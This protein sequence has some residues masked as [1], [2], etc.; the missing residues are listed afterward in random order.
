MADLIQDFDAETFR[1]GS[2]PPPKDETFLERLE[3]PL[4]SMAAQVTDEL[5]EPAVVLDTLEFQLRREALRLIRDSRDAND[6]ALGS[7][8]GNATVMCWHLVY[9]SE[10]SDESRFDG[11]A[12]VRKFPFIILDDILESCEL[13]RGILFF[14]NHVR[15]L[16]SL[17]FGS[18]FW[19]RPCWLNFLRLSNSFLKRLGRQPPNGT[20]AKESLSSL[21]LIMCQVYPLSERS[22]T[23]AWG[24]Y[25]DHANTVLD[26][27][28]EFEE[29]QEQLP[30]HDKSDDGSVPDYTL[31]ES[32][33]EL[34]NDLSRPNAV[35]LSEFISRL[36]ALI[37]TLERVQMKD[38]AKGSKDIDMRLEV[39]ARRYLTSSRLLSLQLS[40][41][42]FCIPILTQVLIVC[43]HLMQISPPLRVQ[44]TEWHSRAQALLKK[45]DNPH[46][47]L[48]DTITS[49]SEESWRK[50]KKNKCT[51]DLDKKLSEPLSISS[52]GKRKLGL[53][54][55]PL[56]NEDDEDPSKKTRIDT[57]ADL[58]QAATSMRACAPSL[59]KH[60]EDF[61]YV[62]AL[63][64]ESGIEAEYHPKNNPQFCWRAVRLL[65][66]SHVRD[67]QKM[68]CSGDFEDV[69][70]TIYEEKNVEI[71][72]PRPTSVASWEKGIFEEPEEDLNDEEST[73]EENTSPKN[74]D[75]DQDDV[76]M[77]RK[78]GLDKDDDSESGSRDK[79]DVSRVT[80]SQNDEELGVDEKAENSEQAAARDEGVVEA[81][82]PGGDSKS[83]SDAKP[84]IS[85]AVDSKNSSR[86]KEEKMR[87]RGDGR[88]ESG[89]AAMDKN[90]WNSGQKN[91]REASRGADDHGPRNEP[92]R[93]GGREDRPRE[94]ARD[95][96]RGR[97]QQRERDMDHRGSRGGRRS[98]DD[99]DLRRDENE[100]VRGRAN[101][102]RYDHNLD[103]SQ[104]RGP[105]PGE[106]GEYRGGGG[107]NRY[108]EEQRRR[109]GERRN[110]E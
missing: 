35:K 58:A 56:G 23:R 46:L 108:S 91:Q 27:K 74:V 63:D 97:T 102:E 90:S 80:G 73:R 30:F 26:E 31:Y 36:R 98:A 34:Q 88:N 82:V 47:E 55:G 22:A 18:D 68:S 96:P 15:P 41:P 21:M 13:K 103:R 16:L 4:K 33:W 72:G 42:D 76:E 53:M 40:D 69:V 37:S 67:L 109:G 87:G 44:L 17:L 81:K 61:N 48:A 2:L 106:R 110:D 62:D 29:T 45:T 65:S 10:H 19:S 3:E 104:S 79:D 101:E 105:P 107:G 66:S 9:M 11:L 85:G 1:F 54:S 99:R 95:R 50:W 57:M 8:W 60:L 78:E 32:F 83:S 39:C 94:P 86:G 84:A 38:A 100:R 64:P 6:E 89:F 71:P 70:R 24:S 7:F 75:H 51:P 93:G 43:G 49:G 59:D 25:N 20:D 5:N 28:E 14:K 92:N 12:A 52:G 77:E